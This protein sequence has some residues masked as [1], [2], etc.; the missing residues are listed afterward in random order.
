VIEALALLEQGALAP[1]AQDAA[2]ATI[3]PKLT[4]DT[5][6]VRWTDA[7]DGVARRIRAFDPH[8]G[9]WTELGAVELKLFGARPAS[10]RGSPGEVLTA[11]SRLL[12]ACGSGAVEVEDVQPGGKSRMAAAEWI[13]GRGVTAGQRLA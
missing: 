12:I 11:D 7:A 8:P 9:A 6:R 10:G 1:R 2:R 3:A 13:R 4:R 5:S